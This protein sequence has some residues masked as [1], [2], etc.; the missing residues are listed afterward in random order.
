MATI[1]SVSISSSMV[2][3]LQTPA[4]SRYAQA[5]LAKPKPTRLPLEVWI[6]ILFF[7]HVLSIDDNNE[8]DLRPTAPLWWA[9]GH[10][11][12]QGLLL[13]EFMKGSMTVNVGV[14][15]AHK[16]PLAVLTHLFECGYTINVDFQTK[17]RK[18][19]PGLVRMWLGRLNTAKKYA[20][21]DCHWVFGALERDEH[22][23]T[24]T[25]F[26]PVVLQAQSLTVNMARVVRQM[27]RE[28]KP[29]Y[30]KVNLKNLGRMGCICRR[31]RGPLFS[32]DTSIVQFP[33]ARAVMPVHKWDKDVMEIT[34]DNQAVATFW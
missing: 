25:C 30:A 21:R 28:K 22:E 27:V 20:H 10:H 13:R 34:R 2:L 5:P 1:L 17:R 7:V 4:D 29:I 32:M 15:D 24:R 26:M 3:T 31:F 18:W 14:E 33:L 12:F 23:H 8:L 16:F 19:T 9:L 11:A 6:K